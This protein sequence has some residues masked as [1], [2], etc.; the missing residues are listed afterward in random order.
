[1]VIELYNINS[2]DS[3]ESGKS[4]KR[5][6]KQDERKETDEEDDEEEDDDAVLSGDFINDGMYTQ[7]EVSGV[8]SQ[9]AMYL[10][11][12]RRQMELDSPEVEIHHQWVQPSSTV[13]EH[14]IDSS[15]IGGDSVNGSSDFADNSFISNSEITSPL[16]FIPPRKAMY[17]REDGIAMMT[18]NCVMKSSRTVNFPHIMGGNL[19]SRYA[20]GIDAED[21]EDD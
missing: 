12:N 13:S 8:L 21:S 10:D 1:M 20:F 19:K 2:Y 11:L 5:C 16:P 15:V 14:N 9:Q 6:R 17:P 7:H 4:W 3:Q 18:K